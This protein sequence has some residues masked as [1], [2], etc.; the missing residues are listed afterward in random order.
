MESH[1]ILER[2]IACVR[3]PELK[4]LV[5]WKI[6][7]ST[8][9]I[10]LP[11][12]RADLEAVWRRLPWI[13]HSMEWTDED[14]AKLQTLEVDDL[15]ISNTELGRQ[16]RDSANVVIGGLVAGAMT[17]ELVSQL[18]EALASA[19]SNL[20]STLADNNDDGVGV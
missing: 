17:T 12:R 5:K 18:E 13:D 3:V 15:Q 2:G 7:G 20:E 4:K 10:Q 19:K 1:N 8:E 14:E 11:S 9:E 6:D 16:Q